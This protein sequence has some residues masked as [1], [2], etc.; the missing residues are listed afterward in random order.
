MER[1]YELHRP[2]GTALLSRCITCMEQ[3]NFIK[4]LSENN[5][6]PSPLHHPD[7][8][9]TDFKVLFKIVGILSLALC[10]SVYH[11]CKCM[12]MYIFRN[13]ARKKTNKPQNTKFLALLWFTVFVMCSPI[14][15]HCSLVKS[16]KQWSVAGI[17]MDVN[18]IISKKTLHSYTN[19]NSA[20]NYCICKQN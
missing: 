11:L 9:I 8:Q 10:I 14:K 18:S 12:D 15:H 16:V 5:E 13:V 19:W 2:I 4:N 7:L 17:Q 6:R 1:S 3:L 20:L